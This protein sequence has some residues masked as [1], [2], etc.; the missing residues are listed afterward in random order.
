MKTHTLN[1]LL[2]D[3]Q[4]KQPVALVTDLASGA[5]TL[6]YPHDADGEMAGSEAT[7]TAARKALAR[8]QNATVEADG[9][10][11]FIHVFNPPRR[12]VV[13]G[14]VHIA[15]PLSQMAALAGYDVTIVDPRGAFATELRFPGV[16][17]V[18]DWPDDALRVLDPDRRT[19]V[20]TLTH[21]PKLDDAAL[22][23]ALRSPAFYI[24]S[25][26]SKKTHGARLTRL[27]QAGFDEASLA[28]IFGPVGLDIGARSP[29]EIAVSIL[30][31]VTA[32]LHRD[33]DKPAKD[34]AA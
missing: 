18:D 34:E 19:A 30:A 10:E 13:V 29:A 23:V 7:L 27:R 20:V 25:L 31:Q 24:G 12:M 2:Q 9:R 3:R 15:Q 26:G 28:R 14:A 4:A 22:T 5:E 6:V 33:V 16:E 11:L 8:N 32:I 21:D 1:R 17:L